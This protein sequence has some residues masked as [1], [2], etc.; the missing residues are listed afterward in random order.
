M[1]GDIIDH[2]MLICATCF[3]NAYRP[4]EHSSYD[5]HQEYSSYILLEIVPLTNTKSHTR[6]KQAKNYKSAVLKFW[7]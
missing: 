1:F 5:T 2:L 6:N 7:K 3:F 4:D